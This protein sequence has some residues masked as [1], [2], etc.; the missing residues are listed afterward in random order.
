MVSNEKFM[1]LIKQ[2]PNST[3]LLRMLLLDDQDEKI[4]NCITKNEN[5]LI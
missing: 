2:Q 5:G 3:M 4:K 1:D